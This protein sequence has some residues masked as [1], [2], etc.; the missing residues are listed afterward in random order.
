MSKYRLAF[1]GLGRVAEVHYDS[2][3]A[4]RDRVELAAVCDI[5]EQAVQQRSAQWNIA[6]F[7]SFS[8]LLQ[9]V[10]LDAVCLLLPHHVHLEYVT[11]AAERGLPIFLEKPIAATLDDARRIIAVCQEHR[12]ALMVAHNGLFHPAFEQMVEF[13]RKGWLGRPLFARCTSAGWLS[14]RPWDF[15][16]S[17]K[18]TGGGCWIDGGGHLVYCLRE[19][20][21]KVVEVNGYVAKVSRPEM[22]GED[23]AT[24]NL[25]YESGAL[26]SLVV[27]Y[28]IKLPGYQLDWPQGYE[29][30]IEVY[31]DKGAVTY[32]I[33]PEPQ[34]KYFSEVPEAMPANWCGWLS[35]KPAEPYTSSFRR[36]ME[37]FIDCLDTGRRPRVTG[38]DALEIM[39]VLRA[40]YDR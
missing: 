18:E 22:E 3:M 21:G 1:V 4:L 30:S 28:G 7:T 20:F 32:T 23:L 25:R 2:V 5:R 35:H 15:R 13:V 16:L 19:I 11:Q 37:H 33:S 29:Q 8:Q 10:D 17:K 12:V 40:V 36:E 38:Q 26:A 34:L 39:E 9:Q 14:F 6:G 27:S 24:V 31:G